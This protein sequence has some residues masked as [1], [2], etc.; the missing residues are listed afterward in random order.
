M[1]PTRADFLKD[2]RDHVLRVDYDS[3]PNRR[4]TLKRPG[5][6][7][8]AFT[9]ATFPGTLIYTGDMGTYVF[10]RSSDMFRF[11]RTQATTID[12]DYW[13]TKVV[14]EDKDHGVTEFS[15]ERFKEVIEERVTEYLAS[16]D[17]VDEQSLRDAVKDQITDWTYDSEH[18]AR[19]E[20]DAF[21]H[22][23]AG[24]IFSD[25]WESRLTEFTFH[26]IWACHAI[27]WA[28]LKYDA[29][30]ETT[31]RFDRLITGDRT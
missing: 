22:P 4:I 29:M 20:V 7:T 23:E 15:D 24:Y 13:S 25:F 10:Q 21:D 26:F 30:T 1:K 14:A 12:P 3:G 18:H 19:T 17:D 16:N 27:P 9:I 11:F 6:G 31:T 8:Y 28:I 5:S 2:V